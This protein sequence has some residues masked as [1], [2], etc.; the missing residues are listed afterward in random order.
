M[1]RRSP[2]N[3]S[4]EQFAGYSLVLRAMCL[5]LWLVCMDHAFAQS[6]SPPGGRRG[7][8]IDK[9]TA[10]RVNCVACHSEEPAGT[11]PEIATCLRCHGGTY[12]GLAAKTQLV[13]PNPHAS[14]Q[15]PVPCSVCH[16]VHSPSQMFCN[17][18]HNFDMTTP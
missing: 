5:G 11:P 4:L 3:G 16:H 17:N 13:Q 15:G 12:A 9:H 8:L 1:T 18:C 7:F 6:A 14:H 2:K 10:A